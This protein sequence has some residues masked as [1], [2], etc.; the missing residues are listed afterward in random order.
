MKQMLKPKTKTKTKSK[1][2][3]SIVITFTDKEMLRLKQ[4]AKHYGLSTI[5]AVSNSIMWCWWE[6]SGCACTEEEIVSKSKV[7]K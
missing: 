5:E 3:H 7:R 6:I 4:V 2:K 1:K